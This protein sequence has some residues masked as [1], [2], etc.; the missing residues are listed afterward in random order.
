MQETARRP[1]CL[2]GMNEGERARKEVRLVLGGEG[3]YYLQG[4]V[5]TLGFIMSETLW[6]VLSNKI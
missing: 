5:R 1:A 2:G 4:T 3:I 6:R